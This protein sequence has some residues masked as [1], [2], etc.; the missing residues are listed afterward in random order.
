MLRL[1]FAEKMPLFY[2]PF[3]GEENSGLPPRICYSHT[4]ISDLYG[5]H[6][7]WP[8]TSVFF[9]LLMRPPPILHFF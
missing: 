7:K 3:K 4:D 1:S 5:F 8:V 9:L 2:V 6:G